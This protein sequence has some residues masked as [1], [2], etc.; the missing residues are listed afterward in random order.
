MR[1]AGLGFQR[2]G[3]IGVLHVHGLYAQ[4]VALRILHDGGGRVKTHG[5]I[6]EQRGGEGRKIV[7]LEIGAGVGNQRKAGG[8]RL[9]KS[10]ER[11]R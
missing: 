2:A 7:A 3:P 11:E 10:I 1:I 5:L 8:V 9:G 6:V 4:A